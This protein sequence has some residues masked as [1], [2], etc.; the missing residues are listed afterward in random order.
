MKKKGLIISTAVMVVVLIASLTTATYAWFTAA[1]KT[2][3]TPIDFSVTSDSALTI[4]VSKTNQINAGESIGQNLFWNGDGLAFDT[5]NKVWIGTYEGLGYSIN[6]G[7]SLI[8]MTKAVFTG[9]PYNSVDKTG[10]EIDATLQPEGTWIM[11]SGNGPTVKKDTVEAAIAN[12]NKDSGIPGNYLD[13]CF[14]VAASK[15][16]VTKASLVIGINPTAGNTV[17]GMNAAISVIYKIDDGDWSNI[18]DIYGEKNASATTP[19]TG[20]NKKSFNPMTIAGITWRD[21]AVTKEIGIFG[22]GTNA[23]TQGEIHQIHIKLFINGEDPDCNNNA[24]NVASQITINFI[25]TQTE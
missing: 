11:A 12:G 23:V 4:G 19:I 22:D 17:L 7:L 20:A 18:I 6:T 21:G 15:D 2:E 25:A 10:G 1:Q 13:V 3:V 16:T 9:T 14:G 24:A 5:E 8:D